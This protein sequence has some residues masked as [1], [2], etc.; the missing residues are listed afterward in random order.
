MHFENDTLRISISFFGCDPNQGFA[1]EPDTVEPPAFV[2]LPELLDDVLFPFNYVL[3]GICAFCF[4]SHAQ[5]LPSENQV[6]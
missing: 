6:C 5:F 1:K 2:A 4:P 3:S